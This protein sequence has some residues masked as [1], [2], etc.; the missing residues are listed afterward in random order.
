MVLGLNQC[1]E[2]LTCDEEIMPVRKTFTVVCA[3]CGAASTPRN[4]FPTVDIVLY[5][6]GQGVLFIERRNPP[7]GWALPGGFIDYGESAEEAA[8]REAREETGLRVR[9]TGLLGVYSDPER[10]P[11]FHTLSVVF[12]AEPDAAETPCAGDDAGNVRFFPLD[13]LPDS[14]AFDHREIVSD[15]AKRLSRSA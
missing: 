8:V 3:Q 2:E 11:R 6:E 5:R 15:F 14:M 9:L 1:L 13:A 10:D 7:H 4:P 12:T